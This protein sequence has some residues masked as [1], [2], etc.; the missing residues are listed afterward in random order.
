M[1]F[2]GVGDELN[3]FAQGDL[4]SGSPQGPVVKKRKQAVAIALDEQKKENNGSTGAKLRR[5]FVKNS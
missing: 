3:K 2:K 1:P 5:P 4:H